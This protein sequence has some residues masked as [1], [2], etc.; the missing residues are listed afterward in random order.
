VQSVPGSALLSARRRLRLAQGLPADAVADETACGEA[1]TRAG[2]LN[3]TFM[4]WRSD[5]A[6]GLL[7][8]GSRQAAHGI[9]S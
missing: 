9:A 7:R 3:P 8:L 2:F 1:V 4:E 6:L 5:L